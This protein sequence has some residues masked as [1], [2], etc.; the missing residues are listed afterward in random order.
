MASR[1]DTSKSIA[2]NSATASTEG[3]GSR[4]CRS[5]YSMLAWRKFSIIKNIK[6]NKVNINDIYITYDL[7][8]SDNLC[9]FM[10]I[11]NPKI[12]IIIK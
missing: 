1:P 10:S 7:V 12:I 9:L 5:V 4:N 3:F 2:M 11:I 6:E 8:F